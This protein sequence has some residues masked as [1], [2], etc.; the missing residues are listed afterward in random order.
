[1]ALPQAFDFARS[2]RD[3]DEQV[4]GRGCG[5]ELILRGTVEILP[6]QH[7]APAGLPTAGLHGGG[8]MTMRLQA[9]DHLLTG[10]PM[11]SSES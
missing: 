4:I 8:Q 10:A 1:M 2:R 7:R 6:Q 9:G 11:S 3:Q 5:G